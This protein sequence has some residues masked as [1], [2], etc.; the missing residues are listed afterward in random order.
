MAFTTSQMPYFPGSTGRKGTGM[1]KLVKPVKL[2]TMIGY[3]YT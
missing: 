3:R 2:V 1:V